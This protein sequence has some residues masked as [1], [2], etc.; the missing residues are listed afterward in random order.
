MNDINPCILVNSEDPNAQCGI[1]DPL[2]LQIKFDFQRILKTDAKECN[3]Q[4]QAAFT[5]ES[6]SATD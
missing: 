1:Q 2:C 3:R 4:L 5:R 6:D